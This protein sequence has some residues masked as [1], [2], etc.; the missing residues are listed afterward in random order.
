M[1]TQKIH[2]SLSYNINT[3]KCD[4]TTWNQSLSFDFTLSNSSSSFSG[5][6]TTG[7]ITDID[8]YDVAEN[9]ITWGFRN[10]AIKNQY[11]FKIY[12]KS[13]NKIKFKGFVNGST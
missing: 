1:L 5:S 12:N 8:E 13:N 10:G 4:K 6:S 7:A 11:H 3:T 2:P 9:I